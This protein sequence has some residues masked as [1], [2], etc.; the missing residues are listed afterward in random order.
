MDSSSG[1]MPRTSG[2]ALRR[3]DLRDRRL[4]LGKTYALSPSELDGLGT[5]AEMLERSE[6]MVEYAVGYFA[7]PLGLAP[8]FLIDSV[9][10]T[11]PMATEE[12]SVIAAATFGASLVARAGGFSTAAADPLMAA[13]IY[14]RNVPEGNEARIL[15]EEAAIRAATD[16]VLGRM[17]RRGGGLRKVGVLRLAEGGFVR[18]ELEIDVRDAMGANI[19]NSAAESARPILERASG[20]T[21]VMA[22]LSNSADQRIA[23]A[24]FAMPTRLLARGRFDGED[25]ARAIVEAYLIAAEDQERAVTH[26]KGIMNGVSALALATANDTRGIEAAV[27]RYATQS[28]HYSPLSRYELSD[29]QLA[30]TIELPMP[31]GTVGGA[32]LF[33]PGAR[34][35]LKILG[36]PDG[37]TLCRIAAA[38]GLAQNLAALAALVS[39]G[40][41]HGH[42][43]LHARRVAFEAGARGSDVAKVAQK[44]QEQGDYRET[45]ARAVLEGIRNEE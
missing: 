37:P 3:G 8:G 39:E 42:M 11:I 40:I 36:N 38:L 9:E 31:F 28:G 35:V 25:V 26:N 7:V 44:L 16:R 29:G 12:P 5:D 45:Y 27:H 32:T 1:K 18:V 23:H 15:A 14:L 33:H 41:Q 20:G 10:R 13:H 24:R 22:I 2:S 6:V 30:G 17:E 34:T 4:L 21:T 19:L 43:R